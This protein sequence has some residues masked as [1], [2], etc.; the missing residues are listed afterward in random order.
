MTLEEEKKLVAEKLMGW[1]I[2][3]NPRLTERM[4]YKWTDDL[5]VACLNLFLSEWNPQS[6]RKWWD[7]LF[8]KMG[9]DLIG[10]YLEKLGDTFGL[11]ITDWNYHI[12]K[13]EIMWKALIE[14]LED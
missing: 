6:E 1:T 10:V 4:K 12:V 5:K 3:H 2:E 13:P 14:T 7:E 11:E 8:D 9:D